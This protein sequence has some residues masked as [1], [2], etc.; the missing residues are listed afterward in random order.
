MA[1]QV[2]LLCFVE[3]EAWDPWDPYSRDQGDLVGQSSQLALGPL[4]TRRDHVQ[5]EDRAVVAVASRGV[6]RSKYGVAGD[7]VRSYPLASH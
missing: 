4:D 3:V 6:F 7:L 1:D 2:A 5:G